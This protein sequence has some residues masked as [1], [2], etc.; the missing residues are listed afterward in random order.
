M[1][2]I[3]MK[4]VSPA[5]GFWLEGPNDAA[6]EIA[7]LLGYSTVIIDMEHGAFEVG[8]AAHVVALCRAL[9][10]E[11]LTRVASAERVPIHQALDS[12]ADGVILP[13]IGNLENAQHATAFAKYPPLGTRGWGGGRTVK[14]VATPEHFVE[15]ENRR[16]RCYAMIETAAALEHVEAIAHLATLDGLLIGPYD[17][18]LSCGRG[19]YLADGRGHEDVA[20]IAQA[21]RAAGKPW[22]MV[23]NS[24]L[25][26]AYARSQG[27]ELLV[28][29]D[30]ISALREGLAAAFQNAI[31]EQAAPLDRAVLQSNVIR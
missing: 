14:Y 28:I 21:A 19:E 17:L 13:Q 3:R 1:T 8:E 4:P 31:D 12:G 9:G 22:G 27:A 11:V 15:A 6:C 20:R 29:T 26:R 18:S 23:V 24:A 7:R 2:T 10:L 16:A 30:D 25:D 5:L